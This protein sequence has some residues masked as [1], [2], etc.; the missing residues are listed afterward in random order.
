M[1]RMRIYRN[2]K[3]KSCLLRRRREVGVVLVLMD[4]FVKNTKS[5]SKERVRREA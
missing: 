4:L 5:K 3:F 1:A 2:T